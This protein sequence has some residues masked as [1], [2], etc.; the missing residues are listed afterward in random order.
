MR[1]VP[2]ILAPSGG[3]S[4]SV[5]GKILHQLLVLPGAMGHSQPQMSVGGGGGGGGGGGNCP[6][7]QGNC[8][9]FLGSAKW[10]TLPSSQ[11]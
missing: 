4:A 7:I 5:G 1:I 10:D 11:F 6:A 2:Q 9:I 8:F 3:V